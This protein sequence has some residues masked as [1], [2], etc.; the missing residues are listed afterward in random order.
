MGETT[1]YETQLLYKEMSFITQ[2]YFR[3]LYYDT[4]HIVH[5]PTL[6]VWRFMVSYWLTNFLHKTW[7]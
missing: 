1:K 5:P 6:N 7:K 3:P 4:L 2:M